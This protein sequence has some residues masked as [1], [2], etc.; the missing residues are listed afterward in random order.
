MERIKNAASRFSNFNGDSAPAVMPSR[1]KL[2]QLSRTLTVNIVNAS[3]SDSTYV[4]FGYNIY[5]DGAS[6]GSGNGVTVTITQSS[7][8][9]VKRSLD[10]APVIL[11]GAKYLTTTS[12]NYAN[13]ITYARQPFT[14]GITSEVASPLNY[15]E[16]ENQQSLLIRIPDFDGVTLDGDTY[17]SGT[18]SANSTITMTLTIGAKVNLTHATEDNSVVVATTQSNPSGTKPLQMVVAAPQLK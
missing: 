2:S 16:P 18:I 4:V 5:G 13:D 12:L 15:F 10:S 7:H 8:A 6:A 17:F 14:G 1:T 9:Q 11:S 3:P